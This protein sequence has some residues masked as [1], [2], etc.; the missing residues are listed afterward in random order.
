MRLGE[1]L[2]GTVER[3][4]GFNDVRIVGLGIK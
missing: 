1:E 4:L 2:N 3:G